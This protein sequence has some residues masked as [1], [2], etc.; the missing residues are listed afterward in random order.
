MA[1]HSH[2]WYPGDFHLATTLQPMFT[3]LKFHSCKV[4]THS[5][6]SMFLRNE[7][8]NMLPREIW[9]GSRAVTNTGSDKCE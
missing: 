5:T 7:H 6:G 2:P 1:L 9:V 8:E 4:S 3:C